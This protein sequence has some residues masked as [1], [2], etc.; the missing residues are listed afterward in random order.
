MTVFKE[1]NQKWHLLPL[2]SLIS[3]NSQMMDSLCGIKKKVK[4]IIILAKKQNKPP[5]THHEKL[6]EHN[7][8]PK[9]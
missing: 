7:I 5:H 8:G 6:N 3:Y 4:I 2:L 9:G 1:R